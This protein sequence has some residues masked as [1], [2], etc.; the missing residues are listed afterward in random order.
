MNSL[1]G[2][3]VVVPA[4]GRELV[5]D[6]LHQ[7]HPGISRMKSISRGFVWW[8][9]MDAQLEKK[10]SECERCQLNRHSP[11]KVPLHPWEWP[12]RAWGRVHIDY[13]GPFDVKMFLLAIDAHSKWLEVSILNSATSSTT[14]DELRKMFATHGLPEVLVS[15][16]GP[17]FSST[18]FQ[19][20]MKRNSIR[21]IRTAPYHPSS[22]GQV[23]RAVQI[24][25]VAMRK[26]SLESIQTR[27]S[28]FLFNYRNTPHT[29]SGVSPSELL[30][31]RRV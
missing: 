17:A 8:P 15:D 28:R 14:I 31:G 22:N 29:T 21:H 1:R 30:L 4:K 11:P 20:F 26:N 13:A 7:G 23:E 18:E 25:K 5:L 10:V 19:E 6:L 16:N 2:T 27:V 9:G 12:P 3:R 24:F